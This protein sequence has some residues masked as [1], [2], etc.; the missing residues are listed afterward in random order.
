MR[1]NLSGATHHLQYL[2]SFLFS[3]RLLSRSLRGPTSVKALPQ[4]LLRSTGLGIDVKRMAELLKSGATML[5]ETCPECGTPLFRKGKETF[6][7]KCNKPVV[8]IQ[9]AEDETRLK[10]DTVFETSEQTLMAKIQEVN[11][12]LKNETDPDRL[13]AYG[14]ALSSWLTAIEKLRRLKSQ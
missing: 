2:N 1:E 10:A 7:A 12:A 3:P 4:D 11:S 8:I 14:N 13:V 9:S 5:S 6:C